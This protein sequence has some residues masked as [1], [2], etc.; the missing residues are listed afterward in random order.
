[1]WEIL[2]HPIGGAIG[3]TRMARWLLK[4]LLK[5]FAIGVLI[6]GLIYT[7]VMLKVVDERSQTPHVHSRNTH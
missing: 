5:L 6:A 4:P 7:Y 2:G 3:T 1:M